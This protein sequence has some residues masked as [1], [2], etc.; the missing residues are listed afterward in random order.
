MYGIP[1]GPIRARKGARTAEVPTGMGEGDNAS[2]TFHTW[3]RRSSTRVDLYQ[4]LPSGSGPA[5]TLALV[6]L[7]RSAALGPLGGRTL[8]TP[9]RVPGNELPVPEILLEV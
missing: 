2:G 1:C 6:S 3:R 7:P 4:R 8:R 9:D 5:M